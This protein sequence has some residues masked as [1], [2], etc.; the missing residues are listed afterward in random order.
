[1]AKHILFELPPHRK[2]R[3]CISLNGISFV[4]GNQKEEAGE[5]IRLD[6]ASPGGLSQQMI[7]TL[8]QSVFPAGG[9]LLAQRGDAWYMFFLKPRQDLLVS[10]MEVEGATCEAWEEMLQECGEPHRFGCPLLVHRARFLDWSL[11]A[12]L[13][14]GSVHALEDLPGFK[15]YRRSREELEPELSILVLTQEYPD[16]QLGW[17]LGRDVFFRALALGLAGIGLIHWATQPKPSVMTYLPLPLMQTEFRESSVQAEVFPEPLPPRETVEEKVREEGLRIGLCDV[18]YIREAGSGRC[19]IFQVCDQMLNWCRYELA[20]DWA[21]E[22]IHP[23]WV[24][25]VQG[26]ERKV[27]R[28]DSFW[29]APEQPAFLA[30]SDGGLLAR[31]DIPF[32]G[33]RK[34]QKISRLLGAD[35]RT[36]SGLKNLNRLVAAGVYLNSETVSDPP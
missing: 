7:Q 26:P 25:M 6:L 36:D 32:M 13:W 9:A 19:G 15:W 12:E 3:A 34:G 24:L 8:L 2:I 30:D 23:N 22:E 35:M 1:M 27:L 21:L 33:I 17:Y 28:Q 16:L 14:S 31:T 11:L 29:K 4:D 20:G 18:R 5:A 10:V